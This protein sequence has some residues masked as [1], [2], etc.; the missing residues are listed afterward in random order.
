MNSLE[1]WLVGFELDHVPWQSNFGSKVGPMYPTQLRQF[2]EIPLITEMA[3]KSSEPGPAKPSPQ[4]PCFE[5]FES[6]RGSVSLRP[7]AGSRPVS[8]QNLLIWGLVDAIDQETADEDSWIS[9]ITLHD[10]IANAGDWAVSKLHRKATEL[11]CGKEGVELLESVKRMS[12]SAWALTGGDMVAGKPVALLHVVD[13]KYPEDRTCAVCGKTG[14]K[15]CAGCRN[16]KFC[17][18]DCQKSDWPSH[19]PVCTRGKQMGEQFICGRDSWVLD[20]RCTLDFE[21]SDESSDDSKKPNLILR[22]HASPD[23]RGI[24]F[25]MALAL[26]LPFPFAI[27][28]ATQKDTRA[29]KEGYHAVLT[30]SEPKT[31]NRFIELWE[32]NEDRGLSQKNLAFGL[33]KQG[34]LEKEFLEVVKKAEE[35]I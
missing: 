16:R 31:V 28:A 34:K 14:D 1:S 2:P 33:W 15:Q 18:A 32:K 24:L 21:D 12:T 19:K 3:S 5:L 6:S 22:I 11:L 25:C 4:L 27:S 29:W 17:S 13:K 9:G 10:E 7:R 23:K 20:W 26:N 35:R 30:I 8:G